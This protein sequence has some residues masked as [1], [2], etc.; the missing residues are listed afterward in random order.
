MLPHS[1]DK[2]KQSKHWIQKGKPGPIKA[3]VQASHTK[4]MVIAFFD[5]RGLIYTHIMSRGA[6]IN[7]EYIVKALGTFMRQFK[8]KRPEMESWE[9]FFHWDIVL[10]HT[11][12]VVRLGLPPTISRSWSTHPIRQIWLRRIISFSGE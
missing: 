3:R 12:T 8:K 2:K 7:T 9:R 6:K 11:A 5:C 10:V 1:Q 4:Q